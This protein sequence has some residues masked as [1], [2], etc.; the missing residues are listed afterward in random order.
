VR[1]IPFATLDEILDGPAP[2][3]QDRWG[4][5]TYNPELYTLEH[6]GHEPRD[7][8]E[9]DLERCADS[10]H[11]LDWLMQV[12]ARG[13]DEPHAWMKPAC[14]G[15]LLLA[16]EGTLDPQATVCSGGAN[17][18]LDVATSLKRKYA[19]RGKGRSGQRL[20]SGAR[21][22]TGG[23][24]EVATGAGSSVTSGGGA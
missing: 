18:T 2:P 22:G 17:K 11:T 21:R 13:G 5:W 9:V 6:T 12:T 10:A 1:S 24:A 4:C 19:A 3:P 16:I 20:P 7:Y 15:Y 8:Y 14:L 23:P